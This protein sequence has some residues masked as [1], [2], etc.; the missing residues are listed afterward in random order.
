VDIA[1]VATGVAD[2]ANWK[3]EL[4]LEAPMSP[5]VRIPLH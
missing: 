4:V 3:A 5:P 1:A 2:I